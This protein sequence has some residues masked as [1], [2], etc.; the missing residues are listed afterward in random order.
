MTATRVVFENLS[1]D[2]PQ[3]IIYSRK[4]KQLCARI[5]GTLQGKEEGEEWCWDKAR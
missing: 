5:E 3:R 4:G 1:H 2:F